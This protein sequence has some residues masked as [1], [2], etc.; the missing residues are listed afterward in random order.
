MKQENIGRCGPNYSCEMLLDFSCKCIPRM[1]KVALT[2][3]CAAALLSEK[4]DISSGISLSI[5]RYVHV[6]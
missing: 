6:L 4:G 2:R 3:P 5:L 1:T